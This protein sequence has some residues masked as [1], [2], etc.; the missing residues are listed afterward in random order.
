MDENF[1]PVPRRHAESVL[2]VVQQLGELQLANQ[3]QDYRIASA[4]IDRRHVADQVLD[5]S[6][7][8][9]QWGY[10]LTLPGLRALRQPRIK[11]ADDDE[12]RENGCD[13][14]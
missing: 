14:G 7:P 8:F 2:F 13:P 11:D 10:M 4:E 3:A 9:A 1:R 6:G 5:Y 12:R